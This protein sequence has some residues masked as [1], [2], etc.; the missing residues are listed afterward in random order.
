[1]A[2]GDRT[3]PHAIFDVLIAVHIPDMAAKPTVDKAGRQLRILVVAL[4]VGVRAAWN[5]AMCTPLQLL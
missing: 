4:G 3:Q 1:M 2:Q 5:Q